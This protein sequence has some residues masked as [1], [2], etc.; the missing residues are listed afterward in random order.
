M[1]AT[2][3]GAKPTSWRCGTA[4]DS[5]RPTTW[6]TVELANL[7]TAFRWAADHGDLDTAAAIATYAALLGF[8]V[9]N[10]EP[11]A[12]AEELIEPARAID[13]PRLA[14]LYVIAS[15]VLPGRTDRGGCRLQ[16]RRPDGDVQWATRCRSASRVC[17]RCVSGHRAA[18]TGVELCRTQLAR[19]RDTHALTRAFLVITL[20]IVGSHD[21]ARVAATGLIEAA[22]ATR[23]PYALSFALMAE[24]FAYREL[25]PVRALDALRRGLVIAQESGNHASEINTAIDTG[26][27]RGRIRRPAGRPRVHHSG[28]P[29]LPQLGQHRC[30][31]GTTSF[32]GSLCRSVSPL[33]AGSH[34]RRFRVQ[35]TRCGV[36]PRTGNR[37]RPPSRRPR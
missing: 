16:R 29:P 22:E 10:Y 24:G 37:D 31:P 14:F 25:D 13:H 12:W 7:R 17:W 18:R 6:F 36:I 30:H 1:P 5:G 32:A 35:S 28:D 2:S 11:I 20:M 9:E 34:H 21:E 8:W 33:G 23:N 3:P 4:P 15:H 26:S 19:G 27:R